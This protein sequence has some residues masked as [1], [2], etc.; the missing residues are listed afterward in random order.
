M[1]TTTLCQLIFSKTFLARSRT[2]TSSGGWLPGPQHVVLKK[3]G[4]GGFFLG[5]VECWLWNTTHMEV[6]AVGLCLSRREEEVVLIGEEIRITVYDIREGEC[7]L[8]IEA[9]A[10]LAVDRLEVRQQK[11]RVMRR[12]SDDQAK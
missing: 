10:D 8:H 12:K 4:V 3:T 2:T 11:E 9:P 1:H 7:L 6:R 5:L